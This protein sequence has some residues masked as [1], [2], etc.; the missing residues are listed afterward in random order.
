MSSQLQ[1]NK[2]S[3]VSNIF[4]YTFLTALTVFFYFPFL[5]DINRRF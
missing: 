4:I 3:V 2:E 5:L 1:K